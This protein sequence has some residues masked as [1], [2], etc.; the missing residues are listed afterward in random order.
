MDFEPRQP[1]SPCHTPPCG[2]LSTRSSM[3]S[4]PR[5][6]PRQWP[7]GL[8]FECCDCD[9]VCVCLSSRGRRAKCTRR[10]NQCCTVTFV[11]V[12]VDRRSGLDYSQ[13]GVLVESITHFRCS[14]FFGETVIFGLMKKKK[15]HDDRISKSQRSEKSAKCGNLNPPW[16][17][18]WDW[19]QN[20]GKC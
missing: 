14:V 5:Q 20:V 15:T 19:V 8:S 7:L 17:K 6:S 18:M 2:I 13:R 12:H 1:G 16:S 11:A 4:V 9:C 10:I 3:V